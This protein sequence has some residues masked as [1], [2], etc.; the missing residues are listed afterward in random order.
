[1]QLIFSIFARVLCNDAIRGTYSSDGRSDLNIDHRLVNTPSQLGHSQ[2]FLIFEESMSGGGRAR[3]SV[4]KILWH[5]KKR[6]LCT[7]CKCRRG[8]TALLQGGW[9]TASH[10]RGRKSMAHHHRRVSADDLLRCW[11]DS[12]P[13]FYNSPLESPPGARGPSGWAYPFSAAWR[14]LL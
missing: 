10:L 1:M 3:N 12:S 4:R 11:Y 13:I 5:K 14:E 8:Y 2:W 9:L 7:A 6:W